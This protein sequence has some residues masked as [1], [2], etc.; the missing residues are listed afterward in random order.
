MALKLL[1]YWRD[2]WKF[3]SVRIAA[4]AA[5]LSTI[6]TVS[7]E[8]ILNV[9]SSLPDDIKAHV[10][11]AYIRLIVP[12]IMLAS[13]YARVVH[14]PKVSAQI[15]LKTFEKQLADNPQEGQ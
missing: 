1:P 15:E 5:V 2:A 9:W 10:P 12:L 6:L 3:W 8:I 13:I 7:P 11:A 4:L 14:Q